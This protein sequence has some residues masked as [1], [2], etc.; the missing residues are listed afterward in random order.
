MSLNVFTFTGRLGADAELKYTPSGVAIWSARVAVDYGYG[1]NKGTSWV[2]A[3]SIGKRAESLGKLE[4]QKGAA[5]GGY[6]ELQVREYDK[7]DGGKG[8]A[9]ECLVNDI[10][11]LGSKPTGN[12]VGQ[13]LVAVADD[14]RVVVAI[15]SRDQQAVELGAIRSAHG[16]QYRRTCGRSLHRRSCA[17]VA[18]W[19]AVLRCVLDERLIGTDPVVLPRLGTILPRL[20]IGRGGSFGRIS[21]VCCAPELGE[22]RGL[23]AFSLA[24]KG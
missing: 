9:I 16:V 15:A 20:G 11:L 18:S 6:G 21:G 12:V 7:R 4:L 2:T 10:E 3:K 24:Q 17:G 14:Y 5:I 22:R 19:G 1:D 13:R 8:A 23:C